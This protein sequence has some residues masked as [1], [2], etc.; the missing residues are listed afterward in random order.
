MELI[1]KY[2]YSINAL[3]EHV[4]AESNGCTDLRI[5]DDMFWGV[6][7]HEG[8]SEIHFHEDQEQASQFGGYCYTAT[9]EFFVGEELTGVFIQD[10]DYYEQAWAFFLNSKKIEMNEDCY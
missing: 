5:C 6:I 9:G 1:D 2:R 7:D 3:F 8:F 4:G 10:E